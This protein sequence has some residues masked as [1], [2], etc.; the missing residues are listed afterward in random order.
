VVGGLSIFCT[1]GPAAPY[2][3]A[4]ASGPTSWLELM[5][6]QEYSRSYPNLLPNRA[7]A[8]GSV[9]HALSLNPQNAPARRTVVRYERR[10]N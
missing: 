2:K 5:G 8:L 9:C 1:I 4:A 3:R 7:P 10:R 6:L